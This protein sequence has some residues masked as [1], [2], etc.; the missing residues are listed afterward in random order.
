MRFVALLASRN[1]AAIVAIA[2]TLLL[3][4]IPAVAQIGGTGSL[5]GTVTDSSAAVIPGAT[6][7]ATNTATNA[8]F[9]QQTSS[10]GF[11]SIAALPP[12]RYVLT[13]SAPGFEQLSQQNVS[14]DALNVATV[15]PV[16]TVGSTTD[17]VTVSAAPPLLET[18]NAT[19]GLVMRNDV[20]TSLP[21][22]MNAGPRDP[23]SFVQ[24]VPGVQALSS[25]A[26][27]SSFASFNGGQG[28]MNETYLEGIP[29]TS[30]GTQGETRNLAY[31]ISVEAVDQFQ[32]ETNNS[33]AMYQGQGVA[34]YTI[35]SGSN[36]F[37]GSAYEYF[38]NT[39]LDA[40]GY[41]P[42]V[43]QGRPVE[44]QNQYGGH[45]GGFIIKDKL[46]FFAN[47]DEYTYRSTS[48]PTNQFVPTSG[49]AVGTGG[50]T[51]GDFSALPTPI[52][53]PLTTVCNAGNVCSR[54]AFAGNIIPASRISPVSK[55]LQSYLP[56][57]P[58]S[59]GIGNN[60]TTIVPIG[61]HVTT[62]TSRV[63]YNFSDKQRAYVVFSRGKYQTQPFA[64]ISANTSAIPLPYAAT[65]IVT[66]Q[67]TNA[68]FHH[69]YSFS[70]NVLNQFGYGYARLEVPI[71]S[72][73]A[74]G[75]YPT[76]AG[77]TGL[78]GGQASNA[79]P[80]INFA[81]TNAPQSWAGTNAV[82]NSEVVNTYVVQDNVQWN[83]GRNSVTMG[84]QFSWLQD[85]FTN[86]ND[87]STAAFS[88][89]VNQ[90]AGYNAAGTLQTTTGNAYASYLLGAPDSSALQDNGVK[91]TGA[92][93]KSFA[94]YVQD[95]IRL[96]PNLTLN[97]GL[98]YDI[99]GV[100]H[101]AQDR[102]SFLNLTLP[103]PAINNY[104]GA[105]QF[106][107]NGTASCNCGT[108]VKTHYGFFGP[109]LG[110]AYSVT[111][112]TVVRAGFA[113][114]YA[115]GGAAGGRGG[116][117][118][119]TNQLG[120]NAL[121]AFASTG[122]GAP[123]FFWSGG[124]ALPAAYSSVPQGGVPAY[125]KAPFFN[126]SLNT[127]FYT[128]GPTAGTITYG[129]PEV[130]GKVPAFNNYSLSIQR[131]LSNTTT[132]AIGYTGSQGHNL[133]T[134]LGRNPSANQIDPK[135][136]ALG[137]DLNLAATPA[138]IAAANGRASAA[139]LGT[140]FKLPYSNFDTANG[141]LFRT[142][143]PFPQYTTITDIWPDVGNSNFNA[144]QA[145]L[146]QRAN[147]GLTLNLAYTFSKEMDNVVSTARTSYNNGQEYAL[148]SIDRKHLITSS[149][150][151]KLPFGK[152]HKFA[153]T[154]LAS[155]FAGGFELSSVFILSS[156]APLAITSTSCNTAALGT[157]S[158]CTPNLT[159]GFSGPIAINGGLSSGQGN[160][161]AGHT[162]SYI[163][164]AAFQKVPNYTFGNASRNAAYGLRSPYTW[165]QDV[166]IRRQFKIWESLNLQMAVSAFNVYNTVNFGGVQTNIDSATFGTVASQANSPRKL[167][168]EARVNF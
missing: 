114:M 38:R 76:K 15:N 133:P 160:T 78:P 138:N 53:D 86:P 69:I 126:P 90:T 33:P 21:L 66:E 135:Y 162:V 93:Y 150:S 31:A 141:K 125:Q 144:L 72:A 24:L 29:M 80:A 32:V 74:A 58:T 84:G 154:G 41:F 92:R 89:S 25:Q 140:P 6:V 136:L 117:R 39:V 59:A 157:G 43:A 111:P 7:V 161:I 158:L 75:Q 48:L 142:L 112:K 103:N 107:G 37:H 102:S 70:P 62:V 115:H 47:L 83:K 110:L 45:V 23:T 134:T 79:F 50:F 46:F 129:D 164:P 8:Q 146:T 122:N 99:F 27:G 17:V 28:Y 35:K 118:Q 18:S 121:P 60:Y 65:R 132:L 11:Y 116:G 54:T 166:T 9:T 13:I 20:Y 40:R 167:Q 16:M 42:T 124:N 149:A 109:R 151:W 67:P 55:S 123:A 44:K 34:N 82:A 153:S 56:Y 155:A 95:D 147:N 127:A 91:T 73:T 85:N 94:T 49:G 104:P 120:Y 71:T 4:T 2:F 100:F 1:R 52:Y 145:V 81:G 168:A 14:V 36:R 87:G 130:G 77:L 148:G 143:L 64:G 19:L 139:G 105:L 5:Q 22:A 108:P 63:D 159:P 137:A 51:G 97:V 57:V 156:G 163:N 88:F 165:N 61:L 30:P 98:R 113:I 131:S 119:G 96:L 12:G 26:A 3:S 10:A 128:G 106:T 101:E 68:Q 152:N